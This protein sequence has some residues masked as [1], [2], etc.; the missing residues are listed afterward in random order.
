MLITW[1]LL[2][3]IM[4]I[5]CPSIP[6]LWWWAMMHIKFHSNSHCPILQHNKVIVTRQH[7]VL[8]DHTNVPILLLKIWD[9]CSLMYA[10]PSPHLWNCCPFERILIDQQTNSVNHRNGSNQIK[11]R[12]KSWQFHLNSFLSHVK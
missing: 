12:K 8:V 11:Q 4:T 9:S 2:A 10:F 7:V 5:V 6:L 3:M 1:Q